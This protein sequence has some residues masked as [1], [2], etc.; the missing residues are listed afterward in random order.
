MNNKMT[1]IIWYDLREKYMDERIYP[2]M[3]KSII[4]NFAF[5]LL[6]QDK[7]DE[8]SPFPIKLIRSIFTN[9][10]KLKN[11]SE[12]GE[13]D[14]TLLDECV[15][16]RINLETFV[17]MTV[18]RISLCVAT[19]E[20][21]VSD[22]TDSNTGLP[23]GMWMYPVGAIKKLGFETST[24]EIFIELYREENNIRQLY[25]LNPTTQRWEKV[26][27]VEK[28]SQLYLRRIPEMKKIIEQNSP[29][30]TAISKIV[31]MN[32]NADMLKPKDYRDHLLLWK[33]LLPL[34]PELLREVLVI[35]TQYNI[36][37]SLRTHK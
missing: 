22:Q 32:I 18:E 15:T 36:V 9:A 2:S 27:G 23:M 25:S 31:R 14:K 24:G 37:L 21:E 16:W 20:Y 13:L 19:T 28:L 12:D 26:T 1:N 6:S 10:A 8:A 11:Y 4:E 29:D 30:L 34:L 33:L 5:R 35:L 3:K 17:W 7:N